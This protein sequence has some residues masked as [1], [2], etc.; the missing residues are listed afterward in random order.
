MPCK[1]FKALKG[2]GFLYYAL[3]KAFVL[4]QS[5]TKAISCLTFLTAYDIAK[6]PKL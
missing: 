5:I 4:E 2:S 6:K 1:I 3:F